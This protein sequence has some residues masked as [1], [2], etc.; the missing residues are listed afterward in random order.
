MRNPARP[1]VDDEATAYLMNRFIYHLQNMNRFC[2]SEPLR[3][4]QSDTRKKFKNPA[5][6]A[7][8]SMFGV[9]Y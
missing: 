4:A 7:S 8:F 6:W 1:N 3:L 2:P 9:N 5:Q